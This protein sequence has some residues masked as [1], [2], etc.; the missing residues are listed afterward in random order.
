MTCWR[1]GFRGVQRVQT[2]SSESSRTA[3]DGVDMGANLATTL[4]QVAGSEVMRSGDSDPSI[5]L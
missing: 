3:R 1:G 2:V 5:R 4:L